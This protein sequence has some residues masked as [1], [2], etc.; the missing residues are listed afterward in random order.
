M[1]FHCLSCAIQA[2][3]SIN[4]LAWAVTSQMHSWFDWCHPED[5]EAR[6]VLLNEGECLAWPSMMI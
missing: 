4:S 3:T 2:T 1:P 5:T 6:L